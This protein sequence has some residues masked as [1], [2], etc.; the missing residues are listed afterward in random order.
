MKQA[1]A[2][3]QLGA[4]GTIKM[5]GCCIVSEKWHHKKIILQ[6]QHWHCSSHKTCFKSIAGIA[7]SYSAWRRWRICNFSMLK[8]WR[9]LFMIVHEL[10]ANITLFREQTILITK[11]MHSQI[12]EQRNIV[13]CSRANIQ[14]A[15]YPRSTYHWI[16]WKREQIRNQTLHTLSLSTSHIL[17]SHVTKMLIMA[18]I[19][20]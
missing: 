4:V 8:F 19:F 2:S 15:T 6:R 11:F 17:T 3:W 18:D 9:Q 20:F 10:F 5:L 1:H 12:N 14:T 13:N 16:A 7:L